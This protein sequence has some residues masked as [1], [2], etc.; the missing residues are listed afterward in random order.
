[1]AQ[2]CS[3]RAARSSAASLNF[4]AM[5]ASAEAGWSTGAEGAMQ[6][7]ISAIS[8]ALRAR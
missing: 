7:W 3:E 6:R 2:L 8:R 5:A 1:M 4:S